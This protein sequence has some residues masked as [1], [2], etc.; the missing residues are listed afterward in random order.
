MVE[1]VLQSEN[2]GCAHY[3]FSTTGSLV[4]VPGHSQSAR[5]TLV[6]VSRNGAERPLAAPGRDYQSP[7][8]SPDG[9]RFA[10]GID[11]PGG[12]QQLW[13]YDL[14]REALTPFT[15]EGSANTAAV[16]APDGKRIAFYS[17]K[18]GPLNLFWQRADGSG[19]LERLTNSENLRVPMSFSPDGQLL[20][21]TESNPT[22]NLDIWILHLKDRKSEP[23]LRTPFRESAPRFS[24]DGRWLAYTSNESGQTEVYVRP[25]P[26]PGGK[27]PIST[28]GGTEP[29]WNPN[30]REIF[31]RSGDKMMA[32][33]VTTQP[34]FSAGKP[35]ML[36]EGKY[37]A[38]TGTKPRYDVSA[39]GQAFLMFKPVE[40]DQ[41]APTQINLVLNW[42]E[43][44]KQRV[45]TW[46]K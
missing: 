10:L 38:T 42:T 24:P 22:T 28:A 19:E 8:L 33:G 26:G 20:A 37:V 2:P 17:N 21:F 25:Y 5:H 16:W 36:F 9:R 4:Y 32:V 31:Y 41:A 14:A 3:S 29:V 35:R 40:Q 15:L 34:A 27:W 18:E 6:W 45:P 44:L 43:E 11:E 30:G 46:K 7:Y 13:I 39:D 23:F 12:K 1:G